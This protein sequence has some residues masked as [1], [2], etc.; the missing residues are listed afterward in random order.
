M[1]PI[2]IPIFDY[3]GA[4]GFEFHGIGHEASDLSTCHILDVIM[5][6]MGIQ[7]TCPSFKCVIAIIILRLIVVL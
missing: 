1:F 6:V 5:E 7:S 3:V 4:I 2:R